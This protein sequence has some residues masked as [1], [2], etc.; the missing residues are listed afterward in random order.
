MIVT[1]DDKP[2][3]SGGAA[4]GVIVTLILVTAVGVTLAVV[5]ILWKKRWDISHIST[6]GDVLLYCHH[7]VHC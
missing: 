5:Y 1:E 3:G 2:G 7:Q 4:A 6:G